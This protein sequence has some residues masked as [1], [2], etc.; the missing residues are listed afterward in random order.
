MSFTLTSFLKTKDGG[1]VLSI[2]WGFG[3]ACLFRQVCKDRSCIIYHAPNP[4]DFDDKIYEYGENKCYKYEI[5]NS[6]C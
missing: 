3:L 4:N 6:K 2:I 5:K 1:I